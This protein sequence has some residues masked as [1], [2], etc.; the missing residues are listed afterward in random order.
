M[1]SQQAM[2]LSLESIEQFRNSLLGKGRSEDTVKAYTTDLKILLQEIE[3]S[4]ISAEEFCQ[5]AENWLTANRKKVAAK[6][7]GRRLTSLRSFARWAGYGEVLR[8]YSAP[9]PLRPQPHPLPEGI[10]GVFKLINTARNERHQALVALCGLCGL[11][12][13]EALRVKPSHFNLHEMT[14]HVFGKGDK[15]REVPVSDRA[16]QI[17]APPVTRAF[18]EGDREV[19]GLQDRFARRVITELGI[20]ASLLRGIASHDL[21]ATF[22]TE[23]AA[24]GVHLRVIQELLGHANS[25]TTEVYTEVKMT[26]MRTAVQF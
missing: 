11:R 23:L 3:E 14:L 12:V 24:R 17:L 18:C 25:K 2:I 26:Q 7:T 16:W 6:T 21:R 1:L 15:E 4:E 22:A 19:V 10:E 5:T 20:K 9:T 8:D 13:S